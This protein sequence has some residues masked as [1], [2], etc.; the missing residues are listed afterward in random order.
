L[1]SGSHSPE[2]ASEV[3]TMITAAMPDFRLDIEDI[4]G[5][6]GRATVRLRMPGT[7]TGGPLLGQPATGRRLSASAVF[8]DRAAGAA[9]PKPGRSLTA[10]LSTAS[11]A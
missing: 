9:W 5:A 3:V 4:S 11:Q 8:I 1:S 10:W 6:G 2:G 7:H